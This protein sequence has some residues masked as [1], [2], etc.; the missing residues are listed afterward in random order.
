MTQ[1][2][3][4]TK[5]DLPQPFGPTIPVRPVLISSSVLSTKD[6]KPFNRNF[7]NWIINYTLIN[8]LFSRFVDCTI[9]Y[10]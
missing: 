10:L 4:S 2:K 9:D 6:L 8:G 1:R 3:A 5:F 7:V